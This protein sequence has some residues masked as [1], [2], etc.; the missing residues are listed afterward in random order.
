MSII[1]RS[2]CACGLSDQYRFASAGPN[3]LPVVL[4][5]HAT[6]DITHLEGERGGVFEMGQTV[7][8]EGMAQS[9]VRPSEQTRGLVRNARNSFT[10]C[11]SGVTRPE[12][13]RTGASHWRRL[14]WIR[15][16]LR[17]AVLL[18][19]GRDLDQV[20]GEVHV[21]PV[22]PFQFRPSQ[23]GKESD[24]N[25][26]Q[27]LPRSL[28]QQIPPLALTES[29]PGGASASF[30]FAVLAAGLAHRVAERRVA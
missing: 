17:R 8:G 24:G 23:S 30:A 13:F 14:G 16:N 27:D 15:T 9:V 26:G 2:A 4:E 18:F 5:D 11:L 19:G 6:I 21:H 12:C 7:A 20:I 3:K 28:L 22:Q 1:L 29:I 10:K 25:M